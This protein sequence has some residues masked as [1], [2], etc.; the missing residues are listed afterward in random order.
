MSKAG[1]SKSKTSPGPNA[2]QSVFGEVPLLA[3]EDAV[4]YLELEQKIYDA[5]NP[6]D[7]IEELWA[8]DVVDLFWDSLRLRRLKVKLIAGAK[9]E[10]LKRLYFRLTNRWFPEATLTEWVNGDEEATSQISAFLDEAGLDEEAV[11]A[12]TIRDEIKTLES[13]DRLILQRDAC[14]NAAL[15]ELDRRRDARARRLR[16]IAREVEQPATAA[17]ESPQMRA[18]E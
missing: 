10:A 12:Q 1:S 18:A 7:A 6:Q 11:T 9:R 2:S 3:G 17:I 16:E 15:R 13:V 5:I 8:R 14:R 4:A